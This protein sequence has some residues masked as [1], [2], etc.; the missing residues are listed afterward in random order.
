M[1]SS[2]R[3][4]YDCSSIYISDRAYE[5]KCLKIILIIMARLLIGYLH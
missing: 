5:R 2:N 4:C 3:L 1:G